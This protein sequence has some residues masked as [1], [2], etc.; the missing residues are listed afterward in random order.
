MARG[1]FRVDFDNSDDFIVNVRKDGEFL[2]A[3][4]RIAPDVTLP[5]GGDDFEDV[6]VVYDLGP[7]R[8]VSGNMTFTQGDVLFGG[9][10]RAGVQRARQVLI[11]AC[12]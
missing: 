5:V 10:R 12:R 2:V 8:T 3:P 1:T 11:A 7:Q 4:F 9:P 6:Q